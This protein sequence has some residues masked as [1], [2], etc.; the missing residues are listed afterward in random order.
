MQI[1]CQ[2]P[3]KEKILTEGSTKN[4]IFEEE[5]KTWDNFFHPFRL[6]IVCF[7]PALATFDTFGHNIGPMLAKELR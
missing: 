5:G 4:P 2:F 1:S 3:D 6:K 7:S